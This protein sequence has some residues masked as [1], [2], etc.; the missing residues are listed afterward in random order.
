MPRQNT[1]K[2][3]QRQALNIHLSIA[4]MEKPT[5]IWQQVDNLLQTLTGM[6]K[7]SDNVDFKPPLPTTTTTL[8]LSRLE[9]VD[10][11]E[12]H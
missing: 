4:L 1:L 3:A 9:K 8:I 2:T 5:T 12:R 11:W 7:F 6:P 10:F